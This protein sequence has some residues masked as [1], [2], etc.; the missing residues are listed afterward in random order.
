MNA[1]ERIRE[2]VLAGQLT[3]SQVSEA[4]G[5]SI[6]GIHYIVQ[7]PERD[8]RISTYQALESAVQKLLPEQSETPTPQEVAS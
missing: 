6:S 4:S 7:R 2:A 1:I 8:L 3:L 5:L